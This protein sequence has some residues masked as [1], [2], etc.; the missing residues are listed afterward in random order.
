MQK[1][2]TAIRCLNPII[3]IKIENRKL[4]GLFAIVIAF[5]GLAGVVEAQQPKKSLG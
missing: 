1:Y 5:A 2:R 3:K 4:A